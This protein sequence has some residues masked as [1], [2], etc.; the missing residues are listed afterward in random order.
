MINPIAGK[1]ILLGV[2]GSIDIYKAADLASKLKQ[3]VANVDV[4]FQKK[5]LI[6]ESTHIPSS[7]QESLH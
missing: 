3:M 6:Y 4:I 2:T 5:R 1:T 7:W